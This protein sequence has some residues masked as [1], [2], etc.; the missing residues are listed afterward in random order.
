MVPVISVNAYPFFIVAF[1]N[2]T[3]HLEDTGIGVFGLHSAAQYYV[4]QIWK[5]GPRVFSISR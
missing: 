2:L 1:S 3:C 4:D 5:Y